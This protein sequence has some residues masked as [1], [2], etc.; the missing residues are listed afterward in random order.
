[1]SHTPHRW[2]M[3]TKSCCF[4][5]FCF[6]FINY[7]KFGI[8]Q[9]W[10][11]EVIFTRPRKTYTGKHI[12]IWVG[13]R[14]KCFRVEG[15][16]GE[17]SMLLVFFSEYTVLCCAALQHSL[18]TEIRYQPTV[19]SHARRWSLLKFP[20]N[21][22]KYGSRRPIVSIFT[23]QLLSVCCPS[24]PLLPSSV[25]RLCDKFDQLKLKHRLLL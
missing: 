8:V 14:R 12:Q 22:R 11:E 10:G 24:L 4:S 20:P 18:S 2:D 5:S 23:H 21:L 6:F 17:K 1:M 25:S 15:K 16:G 7:F 13:G 3:K 19:L 9:F